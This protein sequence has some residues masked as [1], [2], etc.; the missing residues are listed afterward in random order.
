MTKPTIFIISLL[1]LTTNS[2]ASRLESASAKCKYIL[3]FGEIVVKK[4]D[5]NTISAKIYSLNLD[6]KRKSLDYEL[7]ELNYVEDENGYISPDQNIR[8]SIFRSKPGTQVGASLT[9][10]S[11]DYEEDLYECSR[12]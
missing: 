1:L 10:K 3:Q 9:I 6:N 8:F 2:F 11:L 7:D 5:E 12:I 4:I